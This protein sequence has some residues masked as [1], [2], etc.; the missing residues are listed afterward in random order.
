MGLMAATGQFGYAAPILS[1][2]NED[3][4]PSSNYIWISLVYNVCLSVFLPIV[5]RL[6]DIFVSKTDG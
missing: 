6:S 5:G 1:V 4:G 3:L 2:I